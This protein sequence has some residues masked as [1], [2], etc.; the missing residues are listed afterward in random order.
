VTDPDN[1]GGGGLVVAPTTAQGTA[2][3][4]AQTLP[5]TEQEA[6]AATVVRGLDSPEQQKAA[7]GVVVGALPA[8]AK[9]DLA[10][11]VVR[12]MDSPEQ[13]KAAAQSALGALSAPQQAQVAESV[14]G[15]PDAKTRQ[16]LWYIVVGTMAVAVFFFGSM[17]FALIYPEEGGGGTARAG[18]DGARC[19]RRPGSHQSGDQAL[20]VSGQRPSSGPGRGTR[21]MPAAASTRATNARLPAV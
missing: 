19:A 13:Q 9:Q 2:D 17:A 20:G 16:R 21:V 11:A 7:A 3:P 12:S 4:A 10:A 15:S 18:D 5:P 1:Q 6:L 8:A 14:L